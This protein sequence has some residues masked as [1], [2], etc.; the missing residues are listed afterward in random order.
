MIIRLILPLCASVF[1]FVS[2]ADAAEGLIFDREIPLRKIEA[3]FQLADGAAWDGRS[4]LFVPDVK[5]KQ[6]LVF[7]LA[8]PNEAPKVR[9]TGLAISGC[10][11]QQGRLYFSDNGNSQISVL[12]SSGP[13]KTLAQLDPKNRPNDLTVD[14]DGNGYATVTR[15]G[16]V[17]CFDAGA[18]ATE[19]GRVVVK[20]LV[21]P[22]GIAISP[23]GT[24]LY[25]S[26]A[27]SGV[28][29]KISIDPSAQ[30]WVP[31]KF[32][33]LDQ[34]ENGFRGDGMCVDRAG[35]VYCTGAQNITVFDA[36]GKQLEQLK[37]PERPI[38]VIIGGTDARS[39]YISTLG[40]LYEQRL[41]AYGVLP[42][43]PTTKA[44]A[45]TN[46]ASTVI[47]PNLRAE[48]NQVYGEVDGRK[49]LMDVFTPPGN[50]T[51]PRP[52]II[53]VHGGGWLKGD[54]TKFRALA[55]KIAS[56]G[57]VTAAIEYRLGY[58][59]KFPAAIRDCNLA[60]SYLRKHANQFGIDPNRIGAV[61]GSAGGHLV[62]LMATG[63]NTADLH[64][65]FAPQTTSQLQT[66]VVLAGPLQVAT[67]SVADR[68]HEM[69]TKS[70]AV[71]WI[72]GTIDEAPKM[73][74]L[75]DAHQKIDSQTPPTLFIA[76]SLDNP[77]RNAASRSKLQELGITTKLIVH[78][79]ATHGHWNRADWIDRVVAD[80]DSFTKEHL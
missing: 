33:Q 32:A 5:G 57:Y 47:P 2:L 15:E 60:T 18:A 25:V 53:V 79:K 40:G 6:L 55:I 35:N 3:E 11:F 48:F 69:S 29:S 52:A 38:N 63:A 76:G 64:H 30:N 31:I 27:K 62:G 10:C 70:N 41:N 34:T 77:D 21:T 14:H 71:N 26:S 58:E 68:S 80:I 13:P 46:T 66:A 61:G 24:T 12:D 23:D 1:C 28:I 45:N 56:A 36:N 65:S 4:R 17:R 72:G 74:A 54:K 9:N 67:G 16:V 37:T 19:Q 59:A 51:A 73:Y 44:F 39:L 49:L 43:P 22:N 20:N 50:S 7:N 8:K 78:D 75:A 42:N